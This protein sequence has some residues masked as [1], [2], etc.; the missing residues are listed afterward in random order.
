MNEFAHGQDSCHHHI[1]GLQTI[2]LARKIEEEL[3]CA[4]LMKDKLNLNDSLAKVPFTLWSELTS[5]RIN[6]G[7]HWNC[8][9]DAGK[10]AFRVSKDFGLRGSGQVAAIRMLVL[11]FVSVVILASA[12]PFLR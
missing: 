7:R 10:T 11:I 8:K 4:G 6:L 2:T 3:R 9:K 12:L 5:S 1:Y